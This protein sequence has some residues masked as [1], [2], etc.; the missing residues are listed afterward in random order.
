MP[1]GRRKLALIGYY[2]VT[3]HIRVCFFL[4]TLD[5]FIISWRKL[6]LKLQV[7]IE[8][9]WKIGPGKLKLTKPTFFSRMT[10]RRPSTVHDEYWHVHTDTVSAT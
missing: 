3:S 8:K 6:N 9:K 1:K 2:S 10:D 4:T 5:H 7:E